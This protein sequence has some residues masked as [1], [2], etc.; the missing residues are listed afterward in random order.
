[1]STCNNAKDNLPTSYI[2]E[3]IGEYSVLIGFSTHHDELNGA[4]F[5]VNKKNEKEW[6]NDEK[7]LFSGITSHLGIA[8]EQ[9]K[10]YETL[11]KLSCTDEL[12]S[13]A[14]RRSFSDQIT[15]RLIIQKRQKQT[16][17]LLFIYLDNFK[18]VN[19]I[20]GHAKGD[21]VLKPFANILTANTREEDIC[22]R[23]G[24][25]EFAIWLESVDEVS[26]SQKAQNIIKCND[27]LRKLA[28]NA[29][30]PLSL[31]IGV[32]LCSPDTGLTLDDLLDNAD[33][34]LYDVKKNGKS[35]VSLS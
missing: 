23:L 25:D 7:S 4:L 3:T 15:K 10:N 16:C 2:E 8:F 18:Q 6:Q 24:G 11:E 30:K 12:T 22:C 26:A 14:N 21:E 1:M 28:E 19:D 35:G 34:A 32:A 5:I 27:E 9:I 29:E 20:Y 13:L 31:S 17:A 33:K